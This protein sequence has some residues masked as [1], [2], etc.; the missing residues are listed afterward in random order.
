MQEL[1]TVG[2]FEVLE[3][4]E[5]PGAYGRARHCTTLEEASIKLDWFDSLAHEVN[6]LQVA[7]GGIGIPMLHWFEAID[8]KEVMILDMLGI[9]LEE[10]YIKSGRYFGLQNLLIFAEQMLSRVEFIHSRSIVHG[11]LDPWSFR[12]GSR[13]WQS[14]QILLTDFDI[15]ISEDKSTLD[16]LRAIGHILAYFYG[17]WDSWDQYRQ[18][19]ANGVPEDTAPFI[20]AFA[21]AWR[22][23]GQSKMDLI[24]ASA[25]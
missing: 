13:S 8:G 25:Q 12:L 2:P 4:P 3:W 9:S 7:A 5:L 6:I 14:Q 11:S 16:D 23:Q 20:S 18:E 17:H 24:V 19:N 1:K 15:Q 22:V 21:S 10:F